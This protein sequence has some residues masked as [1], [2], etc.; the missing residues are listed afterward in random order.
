MNTRPADPIDGDAL[1]VRPV[2]RTPAALGIGIVGA[3]NIVEHAHIPS[4]RA[5]GMRVVG[6]ASRTRSHAEGV[7]RRTGIPRV[8]AGVDEL[9]AD[10]AVRIVDIAVPP[11]Y[12]PAIVAA[13]AAAGK[14][15]LAQKPLATS[16]AEAQKA[17]GE[18]RRQG[19]VMAV[20]QNGR[21]DPSVNAARSLIRQG[22]VGE[23]VACTM[24]MHIQMPWQDYYLDPRYGRLMMLHMSVHHIDQ[25]RWLFGTPDRVT[26]CTRH[27]PGDRFPGENFATYTLHYADGFLAT[28]VDSGADWASDFGISYRIL[29]TRATLVGEIGWPRNGKS[30]LR[31]ERRENPGDWSEA[32]FSRSWFPDAFSA[33][34]GELM[35]AVE[36]DRL[37][38]NGGA[39]NLDTMRAVFAAYRSADS[40]R[41]VS[42][43][44]IS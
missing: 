25:F 15:I 8:Y 12:Q 27:V 17:V 29:G 36:E 34:M 44:E 14:H 28:S 18:A 30:A 37:P 33:T 5:A 9:L 13:A 2:V 32:R 35:S 26:A 3:G 16:F 1:D 4:Y 41:T 39:D 31:V 19:V 23:R 24:Q 22:L 11:D 20:N 7:A 43:A 38:D 42:L 40:G 21:F 10:P 6:I